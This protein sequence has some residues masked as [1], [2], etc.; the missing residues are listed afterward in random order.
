MTIDEDVA[1]TLTQAGF[2]VETGAF[3]FARS[4]VRLREARRGSL[5]DSGLGAA[6]TWSTD[7]DENQQPWGGKV[8]R[9]G[10]GVR[11]IEDGAVG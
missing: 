4:D 9:S 1:D 11:N 2:P 3:P 7:M 8:A 6:G 5:A 10:G